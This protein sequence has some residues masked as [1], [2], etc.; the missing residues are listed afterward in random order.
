LRAA[1]Q[2][3]S[4]PCKGADLLRGASLKYEYTKIDLGAVSTKVSDTD[5][6]NDAGRDGWELVTIA[7]NNCAYLRRVVGPAPEAGISSRSR[8][9]R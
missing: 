2:C 3:A 7:A 4:R 6:L 1:A 8:P 9:Q 5:V